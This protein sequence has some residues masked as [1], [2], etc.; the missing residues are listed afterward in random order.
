MHPVGFL[1]NNAEAL[2]K[3]VNKNIL[4]L[5]N[6]RNTWDKATYAKKKDRAGVQGHQRWAP[7]KGTPY[8]LDKENPP[9]HDTEITEGFMVLHRI[10]EFTR[11]S[12]KLPYEFW[13]D[14]YDKQ[15]TKEGGATRKGVIARA[16]YAI[17]KKPF[18][19]FVPCI[20][21]FRDENVFYFPHQLVISGADT[22]P[23]EVVVSMVTRNNTVFDLLNHKM[24]IMVTQYQEGIRYHLRDTVSKMVAD[25][26]LKDQPHEAQGE[27][28][29]ESSATAGRVARAF[30]SLTEAS[31]QEAEATSSASAAGAQA[32]GAAACLGATTKAAKSGSTEAS[33]PRGKGK[34][35]GSHRERRGH[36]STASPSATQNQKRKEKGKQLPADEKGKGTQK[37]GGKRGSYSDKGR[38]PQPPWQGP[39]NTGWEGWSSEGWSSSWSSPA[40]WWEQG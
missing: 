18:C 36:G 8:D 6:W 12:L 25:R 13:R 15:E 39:S 19:T 22:L 24:Q 37:G 2:L 32:G 27:P 35:K 5:I 11:L 16:I 34:E 3:L 1:D 30:G 9:K 40:S 21:M 26:F 17:W 20:P 29:A 7:G 33:K 10:I 14:D 4:N 31:S 38:D 28:G 23:P